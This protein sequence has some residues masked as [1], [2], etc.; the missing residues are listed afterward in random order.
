MEKLKNRWGLKTNWDLVA[1]FI[2]FSINGSFAA[3]I[4]K[5]LLEYIGLSYE[6]T[7]NWLYYPVK[8]VLITI[9][10]QITLPLVGWVFGKYDFFF[11]FSKKFLSRIGLSFVFNKKTNNT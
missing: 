8:I 4:G 11:E 10:Y 1:V 2:V 9:V 7:S 3:Y 6:N 5:P